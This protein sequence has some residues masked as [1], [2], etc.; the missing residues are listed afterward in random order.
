ML[1]RKSISCL[2]DKTLD[3]LR[4]GIEETDSG[5][6]SSNAKPVSKSREQSPAV[7]VDERKPSCPND[8]ILSGSSGK[9]SDGS[10][11]LSRSTHSS[12]DSLTSPPQAET[13]SSVDHPRLQTVHPEF[14]PGVNPAE[15]TQKLIEARVSP[16]RSTPKRKLAASSSLTH[17][18]YQPSLSPISGTPTHT[19]QRRILHEDS[20]IETVHGMELLSPP[21]HDQR[22]DSF[23]ST[24]SVEG[25]SS[26]HTP[27]R[28]HQ[29]GKATITGARQ[30]PF[31][32]ADCYKRR[33]SSDGG[34]PPSETQST[35]V[36]KFTISPRMV[37]RR[38]SMWKKKGRRRSSEASID[39]MSRPDSPVP[40][41]YQRGDYGEDFLSRES[42][43]AHSSNPV[44]P[45]SSI[46]AGEEIGPVPTWTSPE[47]AADDDS[48]TS[49]EGPQ[50][51]NLSSS[52][53]ERTPSSAASSSLNTPSNTS[54]RS[55]IDFPYFL[56]TTRRD[57][58]DEVD[59]GSIPE[60]PMAVL[61]KP[62][63]VK[64][65]D[66]SSNRLGSLAA[67]VEDGDIVVQ[68]L[69]ELQ[70]LDLKQNCLSRLPAELMEVCTPTHTYTQVH[71]RTH[72]H[73]HMYTH[74]YTHTH[75]HTHT[76][77]RTCTPMQTHT[78]TYTC[79]CTYTQH[80]YT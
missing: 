2:A 38:L 75:T 11:K 37:F 19:L 67:L 63:L 79:T 65:L 66:M 29:N 64:V 43:P 15:L 21:G 5:V 51:G 49:G 73:A 20:G 30:L 6:V 8:S 57:S 50:R 33:S 3:A 13:A 48:R 68:R 47:R 56:R 10:Q 27:R 69:K 7:A 22:R 36:E 35:T 24:E 55:S 72:T 80:M 40:V 25:H 31:S 77:T 45:R 59:F 61:T 18:D 23:D 53:K 58:R 14:Q 44:S 74:T 16:P 41:I 76:H 54:R 1:R 60:E 70:R 46:I 17:V 26:R 9:M 34:E 39:S 62:N 42:T 78:D 12:I 52:L 4:E 28:R 32:T 71:A